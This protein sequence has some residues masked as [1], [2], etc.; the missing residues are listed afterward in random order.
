MREG[1]G[2]RGER[3]ESRELGGADLQKGFETKFVAEKGGAVGG[4]FLGWD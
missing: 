4:F 3:L 2:W 1:I